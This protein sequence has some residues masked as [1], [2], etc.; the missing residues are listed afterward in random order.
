MDYTS[1]GTPI[2]LCALQHEFR[3]VANRAGLPATVRPYDLRHSFVTFSLVAGVDPKTV[4]REAGHSTVAFTLDHYGHVL[5][6]MHE[7]ASDKREQ[8]L[9]G[10][11]AGAR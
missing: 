1:L 5:Q 8:L 6:E 10:R 2:R 3:I 11:A 4:S 9:K 7:T